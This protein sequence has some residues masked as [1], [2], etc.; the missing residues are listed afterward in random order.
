MFKNL[1]R[2]EK[3]VLGLVSV[4]MGVALLSSAAGEVLLILFIT[5]LAFYMRE[6]DKAQQARQRQSGRL[7]DRELF[8]EHPVRPG[9][10]AYSEH[11][12]QHAMKAARAAG[13]NPDDLAVLPTDIGLIGFVQD[14]EP[15]LFRS[16]DVPDDVDYVQPFVELR[17]PVDA[18]GKVRFEIINAQG[19][20]FFVHEDY[21]DLRRGRNLISPSA[22]MPVHDELET[23]DSWALRVLADGVLLAHHRF[24]WEPAPEGLNRHIREDGEM[25]SE[26]RAIVAESRLQ[27]MSLDDLL[28]WQ[29]EDEQAQ[30]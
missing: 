26:L 15:A 14:R 25:S 30:Q 27:P 7:P 4:M 28:A 22:R 6:R 1:T 2:D 17:V 24:V 23:G 3:V 18:R 21:H 12:H 16:S 29:D 9:R 11:I 5:G 20:S 10:S 8:D 19:D 13:N